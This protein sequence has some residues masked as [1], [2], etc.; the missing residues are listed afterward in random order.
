MKTSLTANPLGDLAVIVVAIE[1][2]L[3][4]VGA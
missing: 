4:P 1:R 2:E 3:V